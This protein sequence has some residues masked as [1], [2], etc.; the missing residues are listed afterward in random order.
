MDSFNRVKID[1]IMLEVANAAADLIVNFGDFVIEQK[2]NPDEKYDEVTPVDTAAQEL[3]VNRLR[4]YF[5]NSGIIAEEEGLCIISTDGLTWTVDPIDGTKEFGRTGNEVAIMIG[6]VY[7]N[8]VIASIILNPF[9]GESYIL[10]AQSGKVTRTRAGQETV[11][12]HKIPPRNK[13][14]FTFEDPRDPLL[15]SLA[16]ISDPNIDSYFKSHMVFA[17]SYGTNILKVLS[18]V[19]STCLTV[20]NNIKPWDEVPALGMLNALG[21]KYYIFDTDTRE[22]T[23]QDLVPNLE[24]YHRP[25]TMITHPD[26]FDDFIKTFV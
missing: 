1:R 24:S 11:L 15:A 14:L 12:T 18:N 8:Q 23:K 13:A 16:M 6:A 19:I 20:E 5:P 3:I 25:L 26:I 4:L 2:F 9:S 10:R 7:N 21:Y 17:G 22:F